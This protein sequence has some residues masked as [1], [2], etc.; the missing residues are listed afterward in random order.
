MANIER[1]YTIPLRSSW[2][3]EPR[4][5]RADRSIRTIRAYLKRHTK[6]ENIKISKGINEFIFSRGVK[7]PPGKIKVEVSGD[8]SSLQARLPGEKI[9]VKKEEPKK[10]IEGLRDRLTKSTPASEEVKKEAAKEE[11]PEEPE[12]KTGEPKK[13]I[14]KE[15]K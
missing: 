2:I 6:A 11:K 8:L 13:E 12:K 1:V 10:G 5:S 15:T 7:K 3:K 9:E 14:K 4:V